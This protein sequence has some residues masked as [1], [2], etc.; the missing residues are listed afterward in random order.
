MKRSRIDKTAESLGLPKETVMDITKLS[1][2][3]NRELY[4]ENHK[5]LTEYTGEVIKIRTKSG[6]IK[7]KGADFLIS[8]ISKYDLLIEGVFSDICFEH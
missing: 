3:E 1:F 7:I 4:V 5:G 6:I 8:H 2:A